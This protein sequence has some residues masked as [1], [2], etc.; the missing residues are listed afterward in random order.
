MFWLPSQKMISQWTVVSVFN[1][2]FNFSVSHLFVKYFFVLPVVCFLS[3]LVLSAL[4]A[5]KFF[6]LQTL[7]SSQN[8]F[9]PP[10]AGCVVVDFKDR[11]CPCRSMY[12]WFRIFQFCDTSRALSVLVQW[13]A[14][15]ISRLAVCCRLSRVIS[16]KWS[17]CIIY[18]KVLAFSNK[19]I[20]YHHQ[21]AHVPF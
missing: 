6:G 18:H 12:L 2:I 21:T 9:G 5:A 15:N 3:T 13:G 10:T 17:A 19:T 7:W 20:T 16:Q 1:E 14:R 8:V 11:E 4:W